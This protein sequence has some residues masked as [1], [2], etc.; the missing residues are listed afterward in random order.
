MLST[1]TR[2]LSPTLV[3]GPNPR[4]QSP[5]PIRGPKSSAPIFGPFDLF[6]CDNHLLLHAE[7][8]HVLRERRVLFFGDNTLPR[9]HL[10]VG[11]NRR[12][13]SNPC[14]EHRIGSVLLVS[15][16]KV[17]VAFAIL[18]VTCIARV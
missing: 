6:G 3:P 16:A 9:R 17:A 4:P 12:W 18:A 8:A 2:R 15:I 5:A 10:S 11:L 14:D 7:I 13:I 1:M